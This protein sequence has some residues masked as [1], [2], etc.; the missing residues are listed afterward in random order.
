LGAVLRRIEMPAHT[1]RSFGTH[2]DDISVGDADVLRLF[3]RARMR[4]ST[5]QPEDAAPQ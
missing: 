5:L 3:S 1:L 4:S 2:F